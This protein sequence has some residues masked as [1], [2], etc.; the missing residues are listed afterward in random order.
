MSQDKTSLIAP[1][2]GVTILIQSFERTG[3]PTA[4]GT[5]YSLVAQA[6]AAT[7]A[8]RD[9]VLGNYDSKKKA[10]AEL[11]RIFRSDGLIVVA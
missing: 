3:S 6:L 11:E 5:F 9:I 10:E 7:D 1:E 4:H 2:S 8:S